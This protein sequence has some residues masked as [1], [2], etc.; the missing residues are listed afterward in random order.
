VNEHSPERLEP[1]RSTVVQPCAESCAAFRALSPDRWSD[2]GL[3]Q[4]P[5]SP[6]RG[7]PVR[8]GRDCRYYLPPGG[9][10]SVNPAS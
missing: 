2:F 6:R 10:G 3:C 1:A 4:H 8:V 9:P 7:Y 5:F